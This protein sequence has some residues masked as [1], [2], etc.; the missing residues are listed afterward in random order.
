MSSILG[1]R[2]V[3]SLKSYT[4][5][6]RPGIKV[7]N[8]A[9]RALAGAN[10]AVASI[11]A[12]QV[13]GAMTSSEAEKQIKSYAPDMKYM[14]S[15][16][17]APYYT[18]RPGD[19]SCEG[20]H[21]AATLL[22]LYGEDRG[23]GS[24]KQ[25]WRIPMTFTDSEIDKVFPAKFSSH[26]HGFYSED[27]NG[28][29]Q[30][31]SLPEIVKGQRAGRKK[32]MPRKPVSRGECDPALC[33]QFGA[34][35]CTFRGTLRFHVPGIVGIK[36]FEMT[37]GSSNAS[38]DIYLQLKEVIDKMGYLPRKKPDGQPIFW[39]TKTLKEKTYYDDAEVKRTGMQWVPDMVA[40]IDYTKLLD[41]AESLQREGLPRSAVPGNW[42]AASAEA[43][44]YQTSKA[45]SAS[46][47]VGLPVATGAEPQNAD[48]SREK[49]QAEPVD[50]LT[51]FDALTA[52]HG[53][54]AVAQKWAS[55]RFG[56]Q[57]RE[58][59]QVAAALDILSRLLKGGP[60]LAVAVMQ[61]KIV[62]SENELDQEVT[63]EFL[64][65]RFG[66]DY[67]KSVAMANKAKAELVDI[68]ESGR[69]VAMSFMASQ[70]VAAA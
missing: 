35:E 56:Q 1:Q 36:P 44:V 26:V 30:C 31:M 54:D 15:P 60:E 64:K 51:A 65:R 29:Q 39:L 28:V 21:M 9:L 16:K 2:T 7:P 63:S 11:L 32:F 37:T 59:K 49:N 18:V 69:E 3:S 68:L 23:D 46:T 41:A 67:F 20:T 12:L 4:A 66:A 70:T 5:R 14:F 40:D 43:P 13:S 8:K 55:G 42:I 62:V 19:F 24:G 48:A 34:G 53:I 45:E 22:E 61:L 17:N 33:P 52:K 10:P 27:V 6:V 57:W 47:D 58:P 50:P 38:E 25:L